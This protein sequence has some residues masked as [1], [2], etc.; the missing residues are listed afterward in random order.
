MKTYKFLAVLAMGLAAFACSPKQEA[1][2]EEGETSAE[3]TKAPLTSK[4]FKS[5]K[6][7]VDSVSYLLGINFGSF[8]RSYNFGKNLN[9][10]QIVKGIKD[11][12]NAKGNMQDPEFV[13][14]FK[15]NPDEMNDVFNNYLEKQ[16]NLLVYKNK[17]TEE[18]FLAENAK[19]DGVQVSES[20]LQY[21]IEEAGSYVKPGLLDTVWVHY[22]GKLIDG[23][24]FDEVAADNDPISFT[25]NRVVKGWSEGLQLV[26]EGGKIKLFVPSALGYGEQGNQAI[27]PN[28]TLIFD[29][30]LDKVGKFVM[31]EEAAE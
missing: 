5:S 18:K 15:I 6:A 2:A 24:V 9:Y 30:V 3:E 17:E 31:P 22:T 23:T 28:S 27:E 21:I 26:G 4:D 7:E 19:K 8:L 12:Q 11:F 1:A 20:G 29:V 13:N 16:H 10:S 14:Q 25:L